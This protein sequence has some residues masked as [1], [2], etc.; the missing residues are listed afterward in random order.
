MEYSE[1]TELK[2]LFMKG[3]RQGFLTH[4][5]IFDYLPEEYGKN[6]LKNILVLIREMGIEV[7]DQEPDPDHLVWQLVESLE[8]YAAEE[9]VE[10]IKCNFGALTNPLNLYWHEIFKIKLLTP[11]QQTKLA[12]QIDSEL[13]RALQA[14]AFCPLVVGQLIKQMEMV[15]AG[16]VRPNELVISLIKNTHVH[17]IET[18]NAEGKRINFVDTKLGQ[19]FETM[20][21][22][23]GRLKFALRN[24]D[25]DVRAQTV[26]LYR[27]ILAKL[28][29][30]L[31][32]VRKQIDDMFRVAHD[33]VR[34]LKTI[35]RVIE[36]ICI[37]QVR[38]PR[39]HILDVLQTKLT[40]R[41]LIVEL[42]AL[43][44]GKQAEQIEIHQEKLK[45]A[46]GQLSQFERRIGM[47]I[48]EFQE[49]CHIITEGE[50]KAN[51]AKGEMIEANL[52]LV[53]SI[54][55]KYMNPGLGLLDLIQEGNIGLM[56]AVDKFEHER[57][58]KFSTYATWWIRQAIMRACSNQSRTIRVPVHLTPKLNTL[59]KIQREFR[60]E[61]GCEITLMELIERM[62][63]TQ[64]EV[65]K[66]LKIP[67]EQLSMEVLTSEFIEDKSVRKPIDIVFQ[68]GLNRA[69]AQAFNLLS[70]RDAQILR[71]RFGISVRTDHTLEE[72]GQL[73]G[74]T[75]ER[76]RQ[77]EAKAISRLRNTSGLR[78][79][80]PFS[81]VEY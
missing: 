78:I 49:I 44:S 7:L 16:S 12:K 24:E 4:E 46:R 60:Q 59:M 10:A 72:I 76:V 70:E 8:E 71:L 80:E 41:N 39:E 19:H 11:N 1:D 75:R 73:F 31:K 57:G 25:D 65:L 15:L 48:E 40:H 36:D 63:I 23:Y 42:K 54:A 58:F 69:V 21:K 61:E 20:C 3:V 26:V 55:K 9:A 22:C 27:E 38:I 67:R 32:F 29:M 37:K 2:S 68:S 66:L 28:F 6:Q 64:N 50:L 17:S 51:I 43:G 74:L 47:P 53:V 13:T 30:E 35:T 33:A 56:K 62:N 34:E 79:L 18:R 52:R 81:G 5:G 14:A 45:E 77:I